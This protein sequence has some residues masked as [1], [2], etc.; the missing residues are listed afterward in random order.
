MIGPNGTGKT[1][2]L[3]TVLGELEPLGG[4]VECGASLKIGYFAQTQDALKPDN[5]VLDELLRHKNMTIS[6]ARSYLARFLFRATRSI[7]RSVH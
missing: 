7:V 1:T 4:S 5:T 3:R 2:F 6:E